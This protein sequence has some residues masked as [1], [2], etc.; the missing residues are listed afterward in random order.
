MTASPGDTFDVTTAEAAWQKKRLVATD[1]GFVRGAYATAVADESVLRAAEP[2]APES[3]A[4]VR[5]VTG[6][7]GFART[8]SSVVT[9]I[10]SGIGAVGLVGE[11]V[12][13]A[14]PVDP[15]QRTLGHCRFS[16]GLLCTL[17]GLGAE[18]LT[19]NLREQDET[20][21]RR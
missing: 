19:L 14:T 8:T 20:E 7:E 10:G 15:D 12:F 4:V 21:R 9:L 5:D 13:L 18:L 11:A 6:Q 17:G 1:T 16:G 3:V 2:L